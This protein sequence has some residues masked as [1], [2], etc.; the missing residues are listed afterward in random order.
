[1]GFYGNITNTSK[2][3]FQ[4]DKIYPNRLSMDANVNNDGIFI[5]RYVLVEYDQNTAYPVVY[6]KN[7]NFYSSPNYEEITRIKYGQSSDQIYLNDIVQNQEEA[8]IKYY[9]CTGADNQGY[10]IFIS[11][12]ESSNKTNYITNYQIDE[13][14]YYNVTDYT[15]I[16]FK[17][18]DSTVWV[19]TTINADDGLIT[20]YVNISD[21]NSVVPTFAVVADAPTMNPI[22][23]HFD[24]DS[25]NVYYKLHMQSPYGFRVAASE[26]K[27]DEQITW[28]T[29]TYNKETDTTTIST[30]EPFAGDIYYN[31]AGFNPNVVSKVSGDNYIK[32]APTAKSGATYSHGQETNDIQEFRL[33]LP[34]IGNMMSD[35]W[36]II[37]G[38]NR[39]DARTDENSSLQGRLDSFK[40]M[41]DNQIPVKRAIDGTLVGT[42]INGN[43]NREII[44]IKTESLH[45]SDKTKDDAWIRTEINTNALLD[46]YGD[47]VNN[48]GISIHHTFTATPDTISISD[49]NEKHE[50]DNGLN[51]SVGDTLKL[52]TPIVDAAGH[53]VGKNTETVTL[54]YGYKYFETEGLSEAKNDLY[55]GEVSDEGVEDNKTTNNIANDAQANNTQDTFAINPGNKWIQTK[56]INVENLDGSNKDELIIAHE[57]HGIDLRDSDSGDNKSSHTNFN[58]EA[59]AKAEH[60][61]TI[62]DWDFD[63]AGHITKKR[64]HTYTLP[65]GYKTIKINN[66]DAVTA[67]EISQNGKT[68][69]ADNTQDTIQFN[70][71]NKWIK[72]EAEEKDIIKFGHLLKTVTP[73]TSEATLSNETSAKVTFEVYNDTFDEAGHHNGRD[74]KTITMPFGYGKITGDTGS[75]SASATFDTLAINANDDWIATEASLDKINITHTGPVVSTFEPKS[76]IETPQFGST[77]TIEDWYFDEKGHKHSKG[78]HTIQFPKGGLNDLVATGSSVLT[79]ISMAP[80]TGFITQTNANVGTLALTGFIDDTDTNGKTLQISST[81][82][83]NTA[84]K[85]IQNYINNLDYADESTSKFISKITQT[86]GKIIVE[87]AT[88]GTLVLGDAYAVATENKELTKQDTINSALGQLEYKLNILNSGS[89]KEGSVAYQIAQIVNADANDK[90]DKLNEIASWIV[91]DTT[92]AAKMANDIAILKNDDST[93]GSVAYSIKTKIKELNQEDSAEDGQY[94]SAVSQT[95]G[96]IEVTRANLPTYTLTS[97]TTNG[98]IKLNGGE[99]VAVTGLGSAAYTNSSAYATAEQGNLAN[100]AIQPTTEF[101]YQK[102]ITETDE[103]TGETIIIKSEEKITIEGLITKIKDLEA[104]ML[105][106]KGYHSS[107]A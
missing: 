1:M 70:A 61:L 105:L 45:I 63:N 81:S 102:E 80:E 44:D 54:P 47:E 5:G 24:A 72:L 91:N 30:T 101:I 42:N 7:N 92:G 60:N 33:H 43:T 79:G 9:K 23:P 75:T 64:K 46:E 99:D 35:A 83:I 17:G 88:A 36:D 67:A 86:D 55:S 29:T 38:P 26:G 68:Q 73:T 27:S 95:N 40:F 94:V 49:K 66:S 71:S 85:T 21:M 76:N 100:S 78:T 18:Y 4:F 96:I 14:H 97:G 16:S 25:T 58:K 19:K 53:V 41:A 103:D 32:L 52:Y 69:T 98:T 65:Y 93:E 13:N 3:T 15:E 37:H 8:I 84:F 11:V 77:F 106:L 82:S 89:S 48:N 104:E 59:G 56:I 51:A 74:T 107:E 62:Y 6:I 57:I 22:T 28:T 10:A 39:D 87:R 31:K 2:T 34:A 12:D 20:K 50:T 90:I